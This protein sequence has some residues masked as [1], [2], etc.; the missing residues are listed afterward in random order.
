MTKNF[1]HPVEIYKGFLVTDEDNNEGYSG[2]E[3][4]I[5]VIDNYI[6]INQG[7]GRILTN[8]EKYQDLIRI[9]GYD[10][11]QKEDDNKDEK[12]IINILLLILQK[13]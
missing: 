2:V 4:E 12:K 3:P 9:L 11:G 7:Y 6:Y 13:A 8:G 10:I 5:D 1:E